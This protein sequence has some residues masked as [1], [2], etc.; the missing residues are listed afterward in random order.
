MRC[1][2]TLCCIVFAS[3]TLSMIGGG[4]DKPN[5]KTLVPRRADA[6]YGPTVDDFLIDIE[7]RGG[8]PAEDATEL[9]SN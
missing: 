1:L 4:C 8:Q 7:R 2:S 3:I 6:Y 5:G 9:D